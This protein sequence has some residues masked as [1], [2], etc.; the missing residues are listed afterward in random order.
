MNIRRKKT[1]MILEFSVNVEV[2]KL[3]NNSLKVMKHFLADVASIKTDLLV[4]KSLM[5][6]IVT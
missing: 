5:R 2:V 3:Y 6:K 1:E 4:R